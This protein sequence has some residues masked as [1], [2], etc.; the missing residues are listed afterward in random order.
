MDAKICGP[1]LPKMKKAKA[2]MSVLENNVCTVECI[3]AITAFIESLCGLGNKFLIVAI[4][5]IFDMYLGN[6]SVFDKCNQLLCNI[7]GG[8]GST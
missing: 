6:T 8:K 1:M 2:A 3:A 7:E 4:S 5:R